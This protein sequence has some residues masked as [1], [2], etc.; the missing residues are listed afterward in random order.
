MKLLI[1][2]SLLAGSLL[3]MP[4]PEAHADC[5]ATR[6]IILDGV[7]RQ[8]LGLIYTDSEMRLGENKE[9]CLEGTF[10]G[11]EY[12]YLYRCE[13]NKRFKFIKKFKTHQEGCHWGDI[14]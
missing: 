10:A 12:Q 11:K 3:L 1:I 8:E 4:A 5:D 9:I 7:S 13:K 6:F 2:L 14:H